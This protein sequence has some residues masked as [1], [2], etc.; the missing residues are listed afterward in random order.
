MKRDEKIDH[1]VDAGRRAD[2]AGAE[3]RLFREA[4]GTVVEMVRDDAEGLWQFA[5]PP[6]DKLQPNQKLALLAQIGTALLRKDQPMPRLTAALEAAV[7]A[8]YEAVRLLVE[9]EIDQ[10]AEWRA[11]PSWRN[12]VLAACWER[13]IDV[14]RGEKGGQFRGI[15][16]HSARSDGGETGTSWRAV[17]GRI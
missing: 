9:M 12:L 2:L 5:A 13:G 14:S 11:S 3:G 6:F 8:V 17:P 10:P 15:R 1:V 16:G 4:L 7:G